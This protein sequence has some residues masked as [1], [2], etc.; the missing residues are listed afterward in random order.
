M[1]KE[2]VV[3]LNKYLA[4]LG[5]EY[6]KLHNLHWNVVGINFKAIHEYLEGLYD[7]VSASLDSVAELL[8]MHDEV[9]AASLKEYLALSSLEELPSVELKG[10]DVLEI[11]LK[12][13]NEFKQL[14]ESIRA[15]ADE[16]DVYDVVSA[17]EADLEQF[18]KS[19][20]F[21]KAMLK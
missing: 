18:N 12:D 13:F 11:V 14:A 2:L 19:I 10:K 4:N 3:A 16:E 8:K 6:I 21:I 7:G 20:W 17:M 5:V 15:L 9:P 1:K